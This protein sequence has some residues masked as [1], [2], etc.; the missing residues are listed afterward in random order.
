MLRNRG[1]FFKHAQEQQ[2]FYQ[3]NPV[4]EWQSSFMARV[5]R[6][7]RDN[8]DGNIPVLPVIPQLFRLPVLYRL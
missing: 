6:M 1:A 2:N 8:F 7:I 3:K 5:F 4:H